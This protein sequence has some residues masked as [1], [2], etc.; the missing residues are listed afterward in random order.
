MMLM[1]ESRIPLELYSLIIGYIDNHT[2]LLSILVSLKVIYADA[3]RQLYSSVEFYAHDENK[4]ILFLRSVLNNNRTHLSSLVHRYCYA[5]GQSTNFMALDLMK[6][7]LPTFTNLKQLK[8]AICGETAALV[9][10]LGTPPFQ[11]DRFHWSLMGG[12]TTTHEFFISSR[13]NTRFKPCHSIP[14]NLNPH[15]YH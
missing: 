2:T 14:V 13:P 10:P 7:A 11:L 1:S 5:T 12:L 9:L 6:Q 4:H 3:E 15:K 8:L